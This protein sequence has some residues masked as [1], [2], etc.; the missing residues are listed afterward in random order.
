M[1]TYNILTDSIK[2]MLVDVRAI[3]FYAFKTIQSPTTIFIRNSNAATAIF[4]EKF[5]KKFPSTEECKHLI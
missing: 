3:V 1:P 4:I 5:I 2:L